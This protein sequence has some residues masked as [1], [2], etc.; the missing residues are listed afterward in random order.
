[1]HVVATVEAKQQIADYIL[2]ASKTCLR[3]VA[4]PVTSS[5]YIAGNKIIRFCIIKG[6]PQ[7]AYKEYELEENTSMY[8]KLY[9]TKCPNRDRVFY[10]ISLTTKSIHELETKRG[11]SVIK[12]LDKYK[13]N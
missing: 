2:V 12:R 3:L 6:Q 9:A 5:Y 8:S 7:P 10:A 1:M 4:I 13:T 11:V